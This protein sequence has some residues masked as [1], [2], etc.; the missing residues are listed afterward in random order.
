MLTS[1]RILGL[2]LLLTGAVLAYVLYSHNQIDPERQRVMA[3]LDSQST[4]LAGQGQLLSADSLFHLGDYGEAL[5]AYQLLAEDDSLSRQLANLPMRVDHARRLLRVQD[6]MDSLQIR[7]SRGVLT[8]SQPIDRDP[9]PERIRSM[10]IEDS[11]PE[12]YDSLTFALQ[13]AEL[14]IRNLQGQL[15]RTSGGNYL[16]FDSHEGNAVYYV[17]DVRDGQAT[18]RGVALLSS[19]SRYQG[20]WRHNE[21]HGFGEFHWPDG[22][23]YEGE[24][25]NDER[26]GEGTYHFPGGEV[27]VG[28]WEDD[29]RNGPG[30][31]YDADGEVVAQGDWVDDELME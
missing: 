17:G 4:R 29:L 2:L 21:K 5:Q 23:Y 3:R 19:G 9:V 13:K 25:E 16:T 27:F 6:A 8:V 24:Y 30:I 20:E 1:K 12:Q 11:R 15:R 22:A 10:D 7:A 26:S 18:G 31:F 28:E 14:Q